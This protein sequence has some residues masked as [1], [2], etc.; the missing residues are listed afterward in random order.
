[1]D[2][3]EKN[4]Q[5]ELESV[6]IDVLEVQAELRSFIRA[7]MNNPT[8]AALCLHLACEAIIAKDAS[9]PV[10]ARHILEDFHEMAPRL[11]AILDLGE[12]MVLQSLKDGTYVD[13]FAMS[14]ELAA[15]E[16]TEKTLRSG[17]NPLEDDEEIDTEV[18]PLDLN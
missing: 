4:Q 13:K 15:I 1:M 18:D 8:K 12:D 16:I 17:L 3:D 2:M 9:P 6:L 5:A 7:R 10:P 14:V 11:E